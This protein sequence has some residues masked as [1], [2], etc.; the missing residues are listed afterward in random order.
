MRDVFKRYV[1]L[2]RA[3]LTHHAVSSVRNI[4]FVAIAAASLVA[5]DITAASR[6]AHDDSGA[7]SARERG[8]DVGGGERG[9]EAAGCS[10]VHESRRSIGG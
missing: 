10:D 5:R 2:K 1:Q 4:M 6:P 8:D 7:H 9:R 3:H